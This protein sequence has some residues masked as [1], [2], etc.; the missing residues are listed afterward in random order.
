MAVFKVA[1]HDKDPYRETYIADKIHYILDP[2][3]VISGQWGGVNFLKASEEETILQF[4]TVRNIYHKSGYIPLQH[5]VISLDPF[6]EYEVEPCQL[7]CI[8]Y[9]IC[10]EFASEQYQAV[11]AVHEDKRHLHAHILVNTVNLA[12]GKVLVSNEM[13]FKRLLGQVRLI[14]SMPHWWHG[15]KALRL[16]PKAKLI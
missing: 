13:S 11:Y 7:G 9:L 16:F 8:A 15:E 6:W 10:R 3:K 2:E 12:D 5:Y 4:Y 1:E 14:L